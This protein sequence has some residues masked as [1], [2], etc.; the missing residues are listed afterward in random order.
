MLDTRITG[1]EEQVAANDPARDDPNRQLLGAAQETWLFDTLSGST[2]QWK[3]LGQQVMFG[4]YQGFTNMDAWDGYPAARSRILDHIAAEGISDVVVLTGDIH[5]S[6]A[7]D[8]AP[9]PYGAEYDPATGEGA[10]AVEFVTPSVTSPGFPPAIADSAATA[11]LNNNP[12]MRYVELKSKGYVIVELTPQ[13]ATGAWYYVEDVASPSGGATTFI[14][15]WS[16]SAGSSFLQSASE[17][18][19]V[20]DAPPLA[21]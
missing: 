11:A 3:V 19:P 4:Q 17:P 12:H 7:M 6:W 15:A 2:A 14:T 20:D 9:N 21:P 5:T 18:G 16:T 1:R 8:I 10:L 13:S